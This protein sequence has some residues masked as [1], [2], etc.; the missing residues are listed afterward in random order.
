MNNTVI[1]YIGIKMGDRN[2]KVKQKFGLQ[3]I[4]YSEGR[5]WMLEARF[6]MLD[7]GGQMPDTGYQDSGLKGINQVEYPFNH[8]SD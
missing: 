7:A 2:L 5:F 6:W 3:K 1:K 4:K 8:G